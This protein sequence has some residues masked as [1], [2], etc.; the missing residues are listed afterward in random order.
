LVDIKVG[1]RRIDGQ[2]LEENMLYHNL[3]A[4]LVNELADV[5]DLSITEDKEWEKMNTLKQ[6]HEF[7]ELIIGIGSVVV[8]GAM[9]TAFKKWKDRKKIKDFEITL[10]H[11]AKKY[12]N[13]ILTETDINNISHSI[14]F[15][16][17]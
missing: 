13:N 1:I 14:N 5:L 6:P 12:S 4:R 15:S 17:N 2:T 16:N 9:I 8:F 10:P 7:I 3:R 11:G